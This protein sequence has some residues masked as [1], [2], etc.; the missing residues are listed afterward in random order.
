MDLN[1]SVTIMA[2]EWVL[3]LVRGRFS[4]AKINHGS[5]RQRDF[6]ESYGD[7]YE[8][9]PAYRQMEERRDECR[10]GDDDE[11]AVHL[12]KPPAN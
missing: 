5:N 1:I 9:A 3:T 10:D 4:P 8:Q 12:F 11:S 2:C 6:G 7:G